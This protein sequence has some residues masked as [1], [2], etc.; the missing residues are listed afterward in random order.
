MAPRIKKNVGE[1]EIKEGEGVQNWPFQ[2]E[3]LWHVDCFE[4]K[5]LKTLWAQEKLLPL[6]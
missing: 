4:W 1:S 5:V 2:E 3:P 6:L